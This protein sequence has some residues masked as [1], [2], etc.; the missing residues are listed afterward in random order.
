VTTNKDGIAVLS[1]N[2]NRTSLLVA[3][4]GK[5]C[6]FLPDVWTFP[7]LPAE[8]NL[9]WHVFDDRS[10]YRPK[11]EVHIKGYVRFL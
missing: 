5:D 8:E 6:A 7:T 9:L 10:M 3:K 11:E 4:K 2:T 1:H